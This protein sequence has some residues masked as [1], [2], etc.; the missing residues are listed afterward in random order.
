MHY[1]RAMPRI[2]RRSRVVTACLGV[3]CLVAGVSGGLWSLRTRIPDW[4]RFADA[5]GSA[6]RPA[7]SWLAALRQDSTSKNAAPNA[8]PPRQGRAED[9]DGLP[10]AGVTVRFFRPGEETP[11]ATVVSDAGGRFDVPAEPAVVFRL[12]AQKPGYHA[13]GEAWATP[14]EDTVVRLQATAG[15]RVEVLRA[16]GRPTPGATLRVMGSSVHP[17]V[18]LTTDGEGL[19]FLPDLP[20][21]ILALEAVF[22]DQVAEL[23]G[24]E[25]VAGELVWA[26]LH[27]DR[28]IF[29]NGLVRDEKDDRPLPGALFTL[30][31]EEPSLLTRV[32]EA[33]GDG[34]FRVGPLPEGAY[35]F[36]LSADGYVSLTGRRYWVGK[37]SGLALFEL[38][39]GVTI[40]G[41]VV[42][43][44]GMPVARAFV[45][46]WGLDATGTLIA[47][48]ALYAP[49]LIPMGQL[50]VTDRKVDLGQ[51]ATG[52]VITDEKG[53]FR[54]TGIPAGHL[55]LSATHERFL[56][57]NVSLGEV[58]Q[59][60]DAPDL[61]L[62]PGEELTLRLVDERD[63]PVT[64]VQVRVESDGAPGSGY[65][66]FSDDTGDVR[67]AAV[68][69]SFTAT[70]FHPEF[71][72]QVERLSAVRLQKVRMRRGQQTL[73]LRLRDAARIPVAGAEV[74][75]TAQDR[76]ERRWRRADEHGEVVFE[77]L[78]P[79]P[80]LVSVTHPDYMTLEKAGV[81]PAELDWTLPYGGGFAGFARDR[82][83]LEG[84]DGVVRLSHPDGAEAVQD[85]RKGEVEFR[86]LAEGTWRVQVTAPGYATLET[87]LVVLGAGALRELNLAPQ[88][89][90]LERAGAV[91]GTV[92]DDRGNP[93][94]GAW[95]SAGPA[96]RSDATGHLER[97]DRNGVFVFDQLPAGEVTLMAWH[98][99]LGLGAET[100]HVLADLQA[101]DV[102]IDLAPHRTGAAAG[103]SG[104]TLGRDPL[105]SRLSVAAVTPGSPAAKAGLVP[106]ETVW[107]VGGLP[108]HL[109]MFML[110]AQLTGPAGA[111]VF[112]VAG[113]T[114]WLARPVFLR[115][116]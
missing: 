84:L 45:E 10:L 54:L 41:R 113:P 66:T 23:V 32:A 111:V 75:V 64:G 22:E 8:T 31:R 116:E 77:R 104:V 110:R 89:W 56:T 71:P 67:L 87:T 99:Q 44:R 11:T 69:A 105:R 53:M 15:L 83:T 95:V 48:L 80:Y 92:R 34:R 62:T 43:D 28:G 37:T 101:P 58:T 59:D 9:Q 55:Q 35:R 49:G 114:E 14:G 72:V 70:L 61:R 21:G 12:E 79:G 39:R 82:Q 30:G 100:V 7:A 74:E 24:V 78:G 98:P 3:L 96:D 68:G 6:P 106:G 50:G 76:P 1:L 4:E 42:D 93:V 97:T 33:G 91:S 65:T 26:H 27:L 88:L 47:P 63:F 85:T 57:A 94:R 19:A 112:L 52:A 25:L 16:D 18:E 29:L 108:T 107:R 46:C 5:P 73:R 40:T 90:E 60:V 38:S 115:L 102:I 17:P 2:N 51:T 103:A 36:S 86:S 81:E 109:P 20:P 13:D